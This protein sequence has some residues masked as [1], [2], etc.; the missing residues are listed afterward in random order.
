M[1]A[2][3]LL[4]Q[5][6]EPGDADW[7]GLG[8]I[9]GSGLALREEFEGA[10]AARRFAVDPG[11]SLEPPG[12]RCGEVL[13]GVTDPADCALFGARCTPEDPSAPAWSAARAPAPP[14]TATGGSMTDGGRILLG[15]GSGGKLYR[16][17]VKDVFVRAFANPV[18]DR[19]DD[20]AVLTPAGRIAFT[21]DAHVVQPLTFPGGDIGRL[22]VA[23]T[24]N[25]L[26]TAAARPLALA[27]AFVIEEGFAARRAARRLRQHGSHGA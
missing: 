16:D 10:D 5:V 27:A 1:V 11:P 26:A 24:V 9:P 6:F 2:Q 19:L 15:H 23:G 20:A 25:D 18:L 8:V 17:L 14:A 22:S 4:E 7:R 12:C 21:T 3:R 13:R